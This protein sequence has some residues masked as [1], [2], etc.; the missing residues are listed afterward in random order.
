MK[1]NLKKLR[2]VELSHMASMKVDIDR[3]CAMGLYER[4]RMPVKVNVNKLCRMGMKR[5][6]GFKYNKAAFITAGTSA[7]VLILFVSVGTAAMLYNNTESARADTGFV[8][9][10]TDETPDE[11]P[12]IELSKNISDVQQRI[13][14]DLT[15]PEECVEL[16]ADQV[17]LADE[18]PV[19]QEPELVMANVEKALNVR[20]EP[21]AD[22]EK[23]GML[24]EGCGGVILEQQDGWTKIE[25][26]DLTGW[27]CDDYLLFGEEALV[28][29]DE[30]KIPAAVPLTS[31]N[32][33]K[34]PDTESQVLGIVQEGD[35]LEIVEEFS[36]GWIQI[37]FDGGYGYIPA[38]YADITFTISTGETIEDIRARQ[39]AEKSARAASVQ[40]TTEIV[41]TTGEAV[42]VCD[43]DINMLAAI[44]WCEAGN[45]CYEGQV[46]V[47]AVVLNRLKSELFPDTIEAV[48][49]APKQ[50]S[51][52]KSGRFD[53]ILA[54]SGWSE[55]CYMAA[56]DALSG[57][58]YVGD[59]HYF[60]NPKIAGAHSGIVIE[61]HVFW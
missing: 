49:R 9:A 33:R 34:E 53:K 2:R 59:A 11:T 36:D 51:P 32:V 31:L 23:V 6:V 50:F 27:A 38:D 17:P 55:S 41:M 61:D 56:L 14:K 47:G 48:I 7:A 60:K 3:M 57:V 24:Y 43:S 18:S 5:P 13:F 21:S 28:L 8:Y 54:N 52:V 10:V 16:P 42:T 25:S 35:Q 39:A 1:A 37:S 20:A 44:I 58:S 30:A 12:V 19:E 29:A 15:V 22:S 40:T 46:S 4:P 26:G 45:Q